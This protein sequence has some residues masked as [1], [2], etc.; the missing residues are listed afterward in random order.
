ML[1]LDASEPSLK[2]LQDVELAILYLADRETTTFDTVVTDETSAAL[3][4]DPSKSA[5]G[6]LTRDNLPGMF[7]PLLSNS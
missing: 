7:V 6:I 2:S 3:S 5:K 4:N 1:Y